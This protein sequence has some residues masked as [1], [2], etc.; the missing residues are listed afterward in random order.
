M[1]VRGGGAA[2]LSAHPAALP[3][4]AVVDGYTG[5]LEVA[6]ATLAV[7]ACLVPLLIAQSPGPS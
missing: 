3:N 6:F 2:F 4:T 1:D 5:A 7:A